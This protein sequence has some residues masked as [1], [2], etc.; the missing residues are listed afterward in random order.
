M[1]TP[2]L[3]IVIAALS[4]FVAAQAKGLQ[5]ND[6]PPAVVKTVQAN[7]KGGE[8]KNISKEKEAGVEQFEVETTLNGKTRDFNVDTKGNLLVVEEA[9]ELNAVPEAA[10]VALVK[11][12]ADGKL[13]AVEAIMKTG[14][15]TMYEAAYTDKRGKRHEALV[16]AD[17]APAKD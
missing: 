16:K 11:R 1:R 10:R 17:G 7:L 2:M 12:V 9:I 14:Q 6:L 13:G 3:V 5:L 4:G 8:I 15:P